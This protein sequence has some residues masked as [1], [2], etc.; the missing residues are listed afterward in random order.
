ML[1]WLERIRGWLE[2]LSTYAV[3]VGGASL[4]LAAIMVA[5][6]VVCRKFLGITMSGSDEISGYVFAASTTWAYS[7]CLLHRSHIRIDALYNVLPAPMR[8]ALD[9]L[10][11]SLLLVYVTVLTRHAWT[12]FM[13][14]YDNNAVS[15]TTLATRLWVPQAFWVIGLILF[16]VTLVFV[17]IHALAGVATRNWALVNRV[18]GML[19]IEEEIEEETGVGVVVRHKAA[20]D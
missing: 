16:V 20:S 9:V 11:L 12:A 5:I 10:A 13:T 1:S 15:I 4:M 7:Y 18:A 6:D 17:L 14:S 2:R 8:A 19:S 3:W